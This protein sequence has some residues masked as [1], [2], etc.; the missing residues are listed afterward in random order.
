MGHLQHCSCNQLRMHAAVTVRCRRRRSIP[1]SKPSLIL[2]FQAAFL[3]S[4][5]KMN[6]ALRALYLAFFISHVPI[7][8]FVDSQAGA[9]ML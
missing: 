6:G 5:S 8:L 1:H 9:Y 3:H 4:K 2:P 7:T